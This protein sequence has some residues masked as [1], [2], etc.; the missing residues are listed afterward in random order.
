MK[1]AS[2]SK[3]VQLKITLGAFIS[4]SQEL[5]EIVSSNNL[6]LIAVEKFEEE[7][8]EL[9]HDLQVEL[10][11]PDRYYQIYEGI[12]RRHDDLDIDPRRLM[13]ICE[14][15]SHWKF[16][17]RHK[18]LAVDLADEKA[19]A[20]IREQGIIHW[21]GINPT[22]DFLPLNSVEYAVIVSTKSVESRKQNL[23]VS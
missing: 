4:R 2:A 3:D 5:K 23:R 11:E 15:E 17:N 21:E 9:L 7:A 19:A 8:K 6:C 13:L 14:R 16:H 22:E 10:N 20:K 1:E 18:A 12:P